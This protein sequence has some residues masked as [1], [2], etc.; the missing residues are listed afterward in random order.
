VYAMKIFV[1]FV[2]ALLLCFPMAVVAR[3][4]TGPPEWT[5]DDEAELGDWQDSYNLTPILNIQVVRDSNGAERNV[6]R[7]RSMGDDAYIYPGGSVPSWEP[8]DGYEY[9]T[10]YVG[11]KV[12][13]T[14]TWQVDYITSRSGSYDD[15]EQSRKFTVDAKPDF[16]DLEFK[17]HWQYMIRGF[18]IRPGINNEGTTEIDYVS[19]RGPVLIT[20]PVKR[21]ATTWG[22]I[23]DLFE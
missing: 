9:G 6:I 22:S 20:Q 4:D 1:I 23:K 18:R 10:I 19:L 8:F 7:I 13:E 11:A 21:L 14:D 3:R 15:V 2:L 5:F 17:M 12:E 16:L